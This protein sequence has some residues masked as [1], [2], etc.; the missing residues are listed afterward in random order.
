MT[1]ETTPRCGRRMSDS[2]LYDERCDVCRQTDRNGPIKCPYPPQE[3]TT[4]TAPDPRLDEWAR[5]AN[6]ATLGP[7][8]A[9]RKYEVGPRSD[10]DDQSCGMCAPIADVYGENRDSDLAFIAAAREA[11]PALMREMDAWKANYDNAAERLLW[12]AGAHGE[13]E[14]RATA[15]EAD[16]AAARKRVRELEAE[17]IEREAEL[18]YL[19]MYGKDGAV[20]HAN[21]SKD[22]W[23]EKARADLGRAET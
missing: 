12:S 2:S 16:A 11:I 19:R 15:A 1:Q 5:L 23:R 18:I 21:H 3:K 22:V 13:A 14:A 7:W 20:W 4:P 10:A 17:N 8:K 6:A 9:T